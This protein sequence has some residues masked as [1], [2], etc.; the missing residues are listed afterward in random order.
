MT[1]NE[2]LH[3]LRG[4]IDYQ[5]LQGNTN[6]A[7]NTINNRLDEVSDVVKSKTYKVKAS[8]SINVSNSGNFETNQSVT[9]KTDT[10]ITYTTSN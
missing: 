1:S 4:F 6:P 9:Y 5:Q 2:F 8:D 3:W 10:P 7:F